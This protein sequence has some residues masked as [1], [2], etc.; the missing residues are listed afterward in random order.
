MPSDDFTSD[1]FDASKF[2]RCD[3]GYQSSFI[4]A[5]GTTF[6]AVSKICN[7]EIETATEISSSTSG[8]ATTGPLTTSTKLTSQMNKSTL[9]VTTTVTTTIP[10][11]TRPTVYTQEPIEYVPEYKEQLVT[12][13][14]DVNETTGQSAS[15]RD[16]IKRAHQ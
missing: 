13:S 12:E 8:V 16:M 6:D 3:N 10:N 15:L 11:V 9:P 5:L 7:Y 1:I 4:C 14:Y 2:Y